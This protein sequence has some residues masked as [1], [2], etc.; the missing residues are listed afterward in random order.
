MRRDGRRDDEF[1]DIF[2]WGSSIRQL[3]QYGVPGIITTQSQLIVYCQS[4]NFWTTTFFLDV[5]NNSINGD[6][7]RIDWVWKA[8]LAYT[9]F[10]L[11]S[12]IVCWA[13]HNLPSF[14]RYSV[15]N[16]SSMTE[17]PI[18]ILTYLGL[19]ISRLFAHF[20]NFYLY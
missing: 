18:V 3:L 8:L 12:E 13:I 5:F 11:A 1:P 4:K 16:L 19:Y 15:R 10:E 17:C 7:V 9:V 20:L 14:G 6:L 2:H